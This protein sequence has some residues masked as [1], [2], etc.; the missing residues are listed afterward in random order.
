ML[1]LS[2]RQTTA[3]HIFVSDKMGDVC[4]WGVVISSNDRAYGEASDWRA[5]HPDSLSVLWAYDPVTVHVA[6]SR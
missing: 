1:L 2:A 4:T 3:L 6:R 5:Y